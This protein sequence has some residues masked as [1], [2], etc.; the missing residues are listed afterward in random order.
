MRPE[1]LVMSAFGSYAG[2]TEIDFTGKQNGLFLITGDTGAGKTTIFDAITY[3]L[4]NQTSGGERNGNMMRSQYAGPETETYVEFFFAY[5]GQHYRVRR[6][7]DYRITRELKNGKIKEQKVS[8]NVELMLPDGTLFPEKKNA[9]DARIAQI[10]GLTAEQFTQTVMIAQGDFLKLLYTKS[11]ER[12]MIFSKLFRTDK[13]W[14]IEENLRRRSL[15]M[16]ERISENERAAAQEQSRVIL[17]KEELAD[18]P[19]AEAV[20]TIHR[21]EKELAQSQEEKRKEQERL[22]KQLAK[23]EEA[24]RLFAELKKQEQIGERLREELPKEQE[25]KEH[26]QAALTAERAAVEEQKKL[27][28]EKALEESERAE[29]QLAAWIDSAGIKYREREKL[30]KELEEK[31]AK[32]E[33]ADRKEI[34]KIEESLPQYAALSL[35][36]QKETKAKESLDVA[37]SQLRG[38]LRN[39]ALRLL[40]LIGQKKTLEDRLNQA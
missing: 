14:R 27:E 10:I 25:R 19:L 39:E 8:H 29:K 5:A 18:V 36:L 38:K 32:M 26:I 34:H 12:K 16:D 22:Q 24:N 40:E 2:K 33:E 7:P 6:N 17:P 13:Y 28:K 1:K 4:Y 35:A 20:E 21:W 11:D 23:A 9:T 37:E 30:L 31:N 3:A 15:T